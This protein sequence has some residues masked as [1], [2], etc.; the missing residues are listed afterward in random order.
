M[1]D[2]LCYYGGAGIRLKGRGKW[3]TAPCPFHG[4]SDSMRVNVSTGAWVCMNCGVKGGDVLAFERERTGCSF[5]TAARRLGALVDDGRKPT[6]PAKSRDFSAREALEVIANELLLIFVVISDA[7]RGLTPSD[8]DW[9]AFI[10]A[11]ANIEWLARE[12]AA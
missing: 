12:Y 4:G 3:R 2:P 5:E 1:P 10:E 6:A 11:A 7:R 9:Q 8:A